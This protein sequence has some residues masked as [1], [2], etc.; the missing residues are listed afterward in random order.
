MI[1]AL[2]GA[3]CL[4][5]GLLMITKTYGLV[6]IGLVFAI[7]GLLGIAIGVS[8]TVSASGGYPIAGITEAMTRATTKVVEIEES[9]VEEVE[10]P[11]ID[12]A[13]IDLLARLITAEVGY[14]QNYDPHDYEDMCYLTGSVVLNRINH[15]DFPD[16]LREVIY[17]S[18]QYQCT[19]NGHIKRAYDD[20]AYEIAEELLAYGTTVDPDVVFQAEFS[21]GSGCYKQIKNMRFCYR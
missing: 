17:Q 3:L 9:E 2:I 14:S 16:T 6:D 19:W 8:S 1:V 13:D 12:K 15:E 5:A 21:Q 7:F 18:G 11:E 4:V 10:I 20:V